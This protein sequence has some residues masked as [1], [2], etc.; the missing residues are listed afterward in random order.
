MRMSLGF[1]NVQVPFVS[2]ALAK[3]ALPLKLL[4][5]GSL[6]MALPESKFGLASAWFNC[7]VEFVVAKFECGV[8]FPKLWFAVLA[9]AVQA[10]VLAVRFEEAAMDVLMSG[11]SL[12]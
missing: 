10:L 2:V 5:E 9:F 12:W 6:G 3:I 4:Y 11:Q 7:S 1:G 8:R